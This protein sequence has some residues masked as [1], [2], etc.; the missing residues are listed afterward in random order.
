[1]PILLLITKVPWCS[2]TSQA[3]GLFCL[4]FPEQVKR[5]SAGFSKSVYTLLIQNFTAMLWIFL[6]KTCKKKCFQNH[7]RRLILN[8]TGW[9]VGTEETN[10]KAMI[11]S[12][13]HFQCKLHK[14][15]NFIF[16]CQYYCLTVNFMFHPSVSSFTIFFHSFRH[17]KKPNSLFILQSSSSS[18]FT[19]WLH[20][21]WNKGHTI[22]KLEL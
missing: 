11:F 1:M 9:S 14:T 15:K 5:I 6:I 20:L 17:I 7:T 3:A 19:N 12:N 8:A 10:P 4:S 22:T 13:A 18:F 16:D 2:K 21:W